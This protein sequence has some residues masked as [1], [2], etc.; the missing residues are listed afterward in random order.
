MMDKKHEI[1]RSNLPYSDY[2]GA[3]WASLRNTLISYSR[4]PDITNDE[5]AAQYIRQLWESENAGSRDRYEIQQQQDQLLLKQDPPI[6]KGVGINSLPVFIHP[7]AK[8]LVVARK[9][10]PLW[11]FLPVAKAEGKSG[12]LEFLLDNR[13]SESLTLVLRPSPNAIPDSHLSWTQICLARKGFL[14]A[15]KVGEYTLEYITM[16][17]DFYANMD[18]HP[19]MCNI[20][21]DRVMIHYHSEMRI[22]WYNALERGEPFD[23]AVISENILE[24]SRQKIDRR[25]H[26]ERL[27]NMRAE[28]AAAQAGLDQLP[29]DEP[30]PRHFSSRANHRAHPYRSTSPRKASSKNA[31]RAYDDAHSRIPPSAPRSFRRNGE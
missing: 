9:Y 1:D 10:V 25:I 14:E 22:A 6:Q 27:E 24:A 20:D 19:E 23:L 3:R 16:F 11:Y 28:T 5:Q 17:T 7:Y 2:G 31:D 18:M 30:S 15:L 12:T 4:L 8:A 21:G 13:P 29:T 26:E